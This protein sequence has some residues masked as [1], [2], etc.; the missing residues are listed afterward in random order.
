MPVYND[1]VVFVLSNY[2]TLLTPLCLLRGSS[3]RGGSLL[4]DL[5]LLVVS[6]LQ[7]LGQQSGV[8]VGGVSLAL[9]VLDLLGLQGSLSLQSLRGDQSLDLGSLG[10]GAAVLAGDFTSDDELS[11][12]IFLG[13][14]EELSDVVGSLGAQSLG[15]GG[16]G[17]TF[18]V[19]VTLLDDGQR[20]DSQVLADD[21][22]SDGLSLS[23]TSS[24]GSV[25]R[26]AL[27]Q[28]E[29]NSGGVQNTLLHGE[30]LLVVTTGDLEDVPLEFVGDGVTFDFLAH[31]LF[32]EHS[33]LVFIVDFDALLRPVQGVGDVQFHG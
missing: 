27:Q 8:F 21:A 14:T 7:S 3:Q 29:L 32:V 31:A 28:Q 15:D 12:V 4:L 13:Q 2:S 17:Q 24:S 25:A 10:V 26:V 23:F 19:G 6:F 20:E 22:T 30:T 9:S 16:V 5:G 11:H 18:D 33:Q 1:T